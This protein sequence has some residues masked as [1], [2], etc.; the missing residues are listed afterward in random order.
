MY[1]KLYAE[2]ARLFELVAL[3]PWLARAIVRKS[4]ISSLSAEGLLGGVP[5]TL[6]DAYVAPTGDANNLQ[7][8]VDLTAYTQIRYATMSYEETYVQYSLIGPTSSAYDP[9]DY[10]PFEAELL[11]GGTDYLR[12]SR[13]NSFAQE[14]RWMYIPESLRTPVRLRVAQ[15]PFSRGLDPAWMSFQDFSMAIQVR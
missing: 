1:P 8:L 12:G 14:M 13:A 11:L 10:L 9:G 7:F 4:G 5:I 15:T 2:I 3:E 6:A